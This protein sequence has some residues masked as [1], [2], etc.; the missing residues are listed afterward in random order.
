[1]VRN[2][3]VVCAPTL[4]TVIHNTDSICD[5]PESSSTFLRDSTGCVSAVVSMVHYSPTQAYCVIAEFE[6]S[7]SGKYITVEETDDR[8]C[9]KIGKIKDTPENMHL[10]PVYV[11][12]HHNPKSRLPLEH[13]VERLSESVLGQTNLDLKKNV[14]VDLPEDAN[15]DVWRDK[16]GFIVTDRQ[17]LRQMTVNVHEFLQTL[18][19]SRKVKVVKLDDSLKE[20]LLEYDHSVSALNRATF[21][22]YLFENATVLVAQR[23]EDDAIEGYLVV[24]RDRILSLYADSIEVAHSLA[25]NWL[26][27][28]RFS[29]VPDE[30]TEETNITRILLRA[31]KNLQVN[32]CCRHKCW[33]IE[34]SKSSV[35]HIIHRRH[36]RAVPANIKWDRTYAINVGMHII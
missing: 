23:D 22:Q 7:L 11:Q 25:H 24:K 1:M 15:F 26:R 19:P 12:V 3:L 5:I 6:R 35:V 36:T 21:L 28:S 34:E 29:K 32:L 10:L 18:Q 13:L 9:L 31:S 8:R 16:A 33:E 17:R 30:K 27:A 20:K 2:S 14:T 4:P